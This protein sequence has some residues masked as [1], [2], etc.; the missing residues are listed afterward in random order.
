MLSTILVFL[1]ALCIAVAA[2]AIAGAMVQFVA[3]L[4]AVNL[5]LHK[6]REE[7]DQAAEAARG[8][9]AAAQAC[10]ALSPVQQARP[11]PAMN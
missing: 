8:L 2:V 11:A 7:R 1:S 9:I 3:A 4:R 5:E 6:L 10:I